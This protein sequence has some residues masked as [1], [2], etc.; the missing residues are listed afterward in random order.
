[1]QFRSHRIENIIFSLTAGGL[2][3]NSTGEKLKYLFQKPVNEHCFKEKKII[4]ILISTIQIQF[5]V[6][7]LLIENTKN[8]KTS[9]R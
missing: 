5:Y 3:Q 7:D 4:N 6:I 8:F 1:M 2:H 9:S